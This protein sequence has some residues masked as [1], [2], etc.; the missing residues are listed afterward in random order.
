MINAIFI[1]WYKLVI[2]L[3]RKKILKV[4]TYRARIKTKLLKVVL[5]FLTNPDDSPYQNNS[6]QEYIQ[7]ACTKCMLKK[8]RN[9]RH[10]Q[11]KYITLCIL[12]VTRLLTYQGTRRTY[13]IDQLFV[14]SKIKIL[15]YDTPE[16]W[17]QM[18][19]LIWSSVNSFVE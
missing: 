16:I 19:R 14:G 10:I 6:S 3:L 5:M 13:Q 18:N 2:L 4:L 7:R 1:Q 11:L 8:M 9:D 17:Y 12:F 15:R